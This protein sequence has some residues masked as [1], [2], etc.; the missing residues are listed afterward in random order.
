M[1]FRPIKIRIRRRKARALIQ[2]FWE[3]IRNPAATPRDAHNGESNA[4]ATETCAQY[5]F[6]YYRLQSLNQNEL[7][8]VFSC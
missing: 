8:D 1:K 6:L 3:Q 4:A 7:S 2:T 5:R